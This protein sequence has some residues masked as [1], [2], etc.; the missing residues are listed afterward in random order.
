MS[1]TKEGQL[2]KRI[3]MTRWIK[4]RNVSSHLSPG[5]VLKNIN[6]GIHLKVIR[7]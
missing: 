6:K 4:G 3:G 2:S 5:I 1:R 7:K